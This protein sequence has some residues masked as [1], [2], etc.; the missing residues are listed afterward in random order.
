MRM[1]AVRREAQVATVR[2]SGLRVSRSASRGAARAGQAREGAIIS[3]FREMVDE[4]L[5]VEERR[6]RERERER[7]REKERE[8]ERGRRQ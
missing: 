1:H 4:R 7:E 3:R 2:R 6:A 8:R 5:Q